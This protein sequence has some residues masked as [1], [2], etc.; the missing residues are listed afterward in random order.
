MTARTL[1]HERLNTLAD[2]TRGRL[3][4]VLEGHELTVGE[5]CAVLQLPQSTVSRHLRVLGDERWIVSRHE[6]TSRFYAL[7]PKLDT[8]AHRLWSVVREDLLHGSATRSDIARIASVL[9]QRP[10]KSREFFAAAAAQWDSVRTELFGGMADLVALL[11]LLDDR[12]T[13]GDLGCGT[14]RLS[15]LLAPNL[16]RI[17]AVDASREM[18]AAARERLSVF[19]NVELRSG[20]LESLPIDDRALD[21]AVLALVLHH[22]AEPPRVLSEVGRVLRPRGRVVIVDMLPHERGEY[23]QHMGHVW[24]GFGDG[25]IRGWLADAGFER[26]HL[27]EIPPDP[28]ARGPTLFAASALRTSDA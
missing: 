1:V 22:T 24:L 8:A 13:L 28:S 12:W 27:H 15:E 18:L 9:A 11:G 10:T 25:Q 17:I 4:L 21:A 19:P 5:L 6:G 16:S 20:E 7:S 2:P 14:G 26:V 3:L 23:T